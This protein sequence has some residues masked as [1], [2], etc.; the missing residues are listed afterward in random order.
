MENF[1]INFCLFLTKKKMNSLKKNTNL[2]KDI[3]FLIKQGNFDDNIWEEIVFYIFDTP[4]IYKPLEER[5]KLLKINIQSDY[6][7]IKLLEITKCEGENHLF[8]YLEEIKQLG[9]EGV[10]LR[11]SNSFYIPG[12]CSTFLILRVFYL[13]FIFS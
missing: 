3:F 1:G 5:Y 2:T 7:N 11:K 8:S 10:L 6:E 13:K 9:E 4:A 12:I